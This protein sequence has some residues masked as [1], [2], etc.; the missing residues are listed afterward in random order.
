MHQTTIIKDYIIL[1]DATFKFALDLL[2]NSPFSPII[3]TILRQLLTKPQLSV[4][5]VYIINR[6]DLD[7][8]KPTVN[9]RAINTPIPLEAVHFS[10]NYSN[11]DDKITLHLAHNSAAC[12]AEWVRDFDTLAMSTTKVDPEVI[13]LI[14]VGC[15]DIGRIGK[16]VI[17]GKTGAIISGEYLAET[18]NIK[19]IK[20]IGAHTWGVGLNTYR[21]IIDAETATD[22]IRFNF[23]SSYGLDP[24]LLTSFI[25][26]LYKDY[27][28][29]AISLKEVLAMNKSG[30]PFVLSRQN[31]TT[32]KLEDFYQFDFSVILKSVQFVSRKKEVPAVTD[33]EQ[34]DGYIF[35]SVLVNYPNVAG[36]NYQCEIWIFKAWDLQE[37]PCCKLNNPTDL[38]Y[39]FTLHSAWTSS[40]GDNDNNYHIDPK[41]DYNPLI[42]KQIG[43]EKYIQKLFDQYVYPNF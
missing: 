40:V 28:N 23:W 20:N 10:A 24:R 39:A 16:V 38:D 42:A 43:R 25:Y 7:P 4:L 37:G 8:T 11:P 19:D 33:D 22:E 17:D 18:G 6:K 32:M 14:S 3:N 34:K 15:M 2:F 36:N 1:A 41:A 35:T 9:A 31:T 21:G 29:R 26:N 27:S 30:V 5:S 12:L 13:G